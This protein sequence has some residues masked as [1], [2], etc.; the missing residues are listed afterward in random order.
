MYCRL[1]SP[2]LALFLLDLSACGADA[3]PVE[4]VETHG[5]H[6]L[7]R[8]GEPY[9]IKGAG[10]SADLG[11]LARIGGN[12]VRTW[13]DTEVAFLD[14]AHALGLSVCVGFWIQHERH[15]FDYSDEAAVAAEIERHCRAI[16][17]L[18]E[19]PAVLMWGIGNEVELKSTNPRVWDVIEAVAAY[20]KKVDPHH[21]TMTVIAQA[22]KDVVE[23]IL[24]RCPSID[25]LGCNAYGGIG[26]LAEEV[27]EAGW[28]GP[29]IVTEW[30]NDGNWE[31]EKTD[32][33]AEIEVSSTEKAAQR[34]ARYGIIAGDRTHCLGAYA[35]H[36]GWKQETTPTWFNLFTED[37]RA[38]ESVGLLRYLWTGAF[39]RHT[40]PQ[41]A[42]LQVNGADPEESMKVE[43]GASLV[44]DFELVRGEA[45]DLTV[46]WDLAPESTDK[47]FGGDREE[48][49]EP[50]H[51]DGDRLSP[52]HLEFKAPEQG[53]AYRLYLTV[54][55]P[56][57][58]VATANFPFFVK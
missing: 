54:H 22:P 20:A 4:L 8:D 37:G 42:R 12:S 2:L 28:T 50:I 14:R 40:A 13:G 31:A 16:D 25:I 30:G 15:G 5:T 58:T 1:L 55:G 24:E 6:L 51:F 7:L 32:W 29:Y 9:F 17:R 19:H 33:G 26:I 57:K 35:F 36:W 46:H 21:P 39:P 52:T 41:V 44:A 49:P 43:A 11:L 34:A 53:G 23:H 10:G 38:T 56:G 47:G 48:R 45:T 3:I 18:K 27:R